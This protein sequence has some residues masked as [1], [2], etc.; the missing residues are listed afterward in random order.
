MSGDE[1]ARFIYLGMLGL[2]VGGWYVTQNRVSLGK[3]AQFAAIWGLIF[4]GV[5]AAVGLWEDVRR[6]TLMRQYVSNDG[7]IEI[8]RADDGHFYAR[9]YLDGVPVEFTIDTGASQVVLTR[10]DARRVGLDPDNLAYLGQA[11]TANGPV[12]T[13][14]AR[15]D[16]F[17]F[18]GLVD[19]RVEVWVNDGA[20]P[21]SLLGMSYLNRFSKIEIAGGMMRLLR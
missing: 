7:T 3:N 17:T 15:V 6:D 9:L 18:E 12:R 4:V 8:P 1:L 19:Q 20:M 14:S 10:E 11:F 2:A 16:T 21:G 13:A 5:I